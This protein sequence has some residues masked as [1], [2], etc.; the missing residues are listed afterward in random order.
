M[1]T[2]ASWNA[3]DVILSLLLIAAIIA[4]YTYFTG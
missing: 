4:I 1:E 2:R 3:K